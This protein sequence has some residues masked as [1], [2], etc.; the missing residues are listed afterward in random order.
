MTTINFL[1]ENLVKSIVQNKTMH[2]G[3]NSIANKGS[4]N[5]FLV[6]IFSLIALLIKGYIIYITYNLIVPRIIYSLSENKT[7][8]NI[9]NNF[10]PLTFVESL[11]LVI[12]T[13]TLFSG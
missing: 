12:F 9:E 10:K 1:V 3:N 11:L 6:L 8:E 5:F 7:L 4:P 13:N 2:G